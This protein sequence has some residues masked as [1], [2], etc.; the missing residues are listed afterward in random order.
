MTYVSLFRQHDVSTVHC[1]AP[2][3]GWG[4]RGVIVVIAV[5]MVTDRVA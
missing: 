4:V 3:A 5:V 1:S 2:Q